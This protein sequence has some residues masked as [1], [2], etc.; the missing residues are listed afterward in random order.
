MRCALSPAPL[1]RRVTRQLCVAVYAGVKC[2]AA[3]ESNGDDITVGVVVG[4]TRLPVHCGAAYNHLTRSSAR[5][6]REAAF[7]SQL[8]T[9]NHQ[10][11]CAIEKASQQNLDLVC[12]QAA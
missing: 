3:F 2:I 12:H 1:G 5:A 10:L 8:S 11:A 6:A 9:L 4:A 7:Y